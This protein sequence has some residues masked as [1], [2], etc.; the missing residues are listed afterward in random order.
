MMIKGKLKSKKNPLLWP[1]RNSLEN[2]CWTFASRTDKQN[3]SRYALCLSLKFITNFEKYFLPWY[4]LGRSWWNERVTF[5]WNPEFHGKL[6]C[7]AGIFVAFK[8]SPFKIFMKL[9]YKTMPKWGEGYMKR[10]NSS[11]DLW[12]MH[13]SGASKVCIHVYISLDS[14]SFCEFK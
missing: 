14:N 3:Y 11:M 5:F 13:I 9:S 12:M 2:L 4:T 8:F 7:S 6:C 1:R 10:E